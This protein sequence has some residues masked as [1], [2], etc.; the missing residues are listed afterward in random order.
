MDSNTKVLVVDDFANMR[1]IIKGI[2]KQLGFNNIVEA[3]DGSAALK[4]FKRNRIG[5]I[6]SGWDMPRMTG[7]DLLKAVRSDENLKDIPFIMV[8]AQGQKEDILE[9]AKAGVS[10]YIGKPF[11]SETLSETIKRTLKE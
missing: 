9:A 10:N 1:R 8:T 3:E 11:T 6:L 4:E 7:L 5:L 2:L